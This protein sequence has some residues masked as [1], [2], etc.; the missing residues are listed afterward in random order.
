MTH[1]KRTDLTRFILVR[2]SLLCGHRV[3]DA[4]HD[5]SLSSAISSLHAALSDSQGVA[6]MH[7]L[8]GLYHLRDTPME[9]LPS[10]YDT[11]TPCPREY[12]EQTDDYM[13]MQ[14]VDSNR[15]LSVLTASLLHA[16]YAFVGLD[17]RFQFDAE[18]SRLLKDGLLAFSQLIGRCAGEDSERLP[19]VSAPKTR[20]IDTWAEGINKEIPHDHVLDLWRQSHWMFY[21]IIQG[22]I[23]AFDRMF[24]ALDRKDTVSAATELRSGI[25]LMW[26]S[27]ASM[28]QTASFS[29]EEYRDTVRPTMALDN[30]MSM[31]SAVNMSG[32]IAWDHQYLVNNIWRNRLS[33]NLS[34][35]MTDLADDYNDLV[36]AYRDGLSKNHKYVCG[37]FG[38][39]E[40]GSLLVPNVIANTNLHRIEL[41]RLKQLGVKQ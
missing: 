7:C 35:V 8:Q 22:L 30:E 9:A 38:G 20:A 10:G 33:Q 34:S 24:D 23:L 5:A 17:N 4:V 27:G 26:A 13:Y 21:T 12:A 11:E 39:E 36:A 32:T 40:T 18:D 6:R 3:T 29:H 2:P 25:A 37:R 41:Q 31:V 1:L 19:E 28:K 16:Y 15:P 14:R